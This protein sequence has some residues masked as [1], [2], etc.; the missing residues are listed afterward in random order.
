MAQCAGKTLCCMFQ[1]ICRCAG[2]NNAL[3]GE[4]WREGMSG[5]YWDIRVS[6]G[7]GLGDGIF[8][9]YDLCID[10]HLLEERTG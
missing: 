9:F 3:V 7:A 2:E 6:R 4:V 10:S 8:Y 1:E 5:G